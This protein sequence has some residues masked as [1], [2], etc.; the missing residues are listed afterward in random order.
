MIHAVCVFMHARMTKVLA[1]NAPSAL[2]D[3]RFARAGLEGGP[4]SVKLAFAHNQN[5]LPHTSGL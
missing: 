5:W 4:N 3:G 1:E 2:R